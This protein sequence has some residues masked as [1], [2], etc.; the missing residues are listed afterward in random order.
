[1]SVRVYIGLG[2]NLDDPDQQ[3]INAFEDLNKI[4]KTRLV[5]DSGLFKSPPMGPQ[6]QPD[7]I[8][9]VALLETELDAEPLL[10]Q[11]QLIENRHGRIRSRHWG[12]R[13]LDLDILLYG[14]EIINTA[15]L[16][17]PHQGLAEREFVLY[18]LQKIDPD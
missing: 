1:M 9:A 10:D 16:I 13:T 15:R 17:V 6:D 8:N 4:E 18:P 5:T 11:L 14:D 3:I 12:E 7:Y 2:S